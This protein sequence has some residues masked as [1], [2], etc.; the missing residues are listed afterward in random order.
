M[1]MCFDWRF[2]LLLVF[3]MQKIIIHLALLLSLVA[4]DCLIDLALLNPNHKL[5]KRIIQ[6]VGLALTQNR[7]WKSGF[8]LALM[9]ITP[10]FNYQLFSEVL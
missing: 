2:T 9:K 10:E 5:Q 3:I 4:K 8:C 6:K 7:Q 1:N